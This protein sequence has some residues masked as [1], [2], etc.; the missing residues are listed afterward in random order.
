MY[1]IGFGENIE[2]EYIMVFSDSIVDQAWI[3]SGGRCECTQRSH[4]HQGRCNCELLKAARGKETS[5]GWEPRHKTAS[6]PDTLINCEILCLS[7]HKQTQTYG[8]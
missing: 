8:N 7:C 5:L 1:E 4:T 6:G 2:R 3:Q